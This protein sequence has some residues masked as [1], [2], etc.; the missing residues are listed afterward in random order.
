MQCPPLQQ[1]T[2]GW[3]SSCYPGHRGL[4]LSELASERQHVKPKVVNKKDVVHQKQAPDAAF[5]ASAARGSKQ[6]SVRPAVWTPSL[7]SPHRVSGHSVPVPQCDTARNHIHMSG[8]TR[9]EM[10]C[11]TTLKKGIFS[12]EIS[13]LT[14]IKAPSG[15]SCFKGKGESNHL[16][17]S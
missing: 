6:L 2:P 4:L 13:L 16:H 8:H 10:M 3:I 11:V 1:E 5:L 7:S 17:T 9:R 15:L 12:F 14:L